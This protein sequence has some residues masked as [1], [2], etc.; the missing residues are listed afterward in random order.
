MERAKQRPSAGTVF[1]LLAVLI[2]LGGTAVA[3]Q[4][5]STSAVGAKKV[6]K[7]AAAQVV[8][9]APGL[10]VASAQTAT[11]ATNATNAINATNAANANNASQLGGIGASGYQRTLRWAEVD[12]DGTSAAVVHGNA[13]GAFKGGSMGLYVVSFEP[14]ILNCAIVATYKR[15]S[16]TSGEVIASP[17]GVNTN[18]FVQHFDSAG[19]A[20]N[21]VGGGDGFY[22]AVFC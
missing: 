22:V 19:N 3:R 9:L 18:V 7:I 1:G 16:G 8:R 15:G 13:T 12:G 10:S 4:S 11:S 6:K 20:A 21:L 17:T 5:A 2:A 14:D